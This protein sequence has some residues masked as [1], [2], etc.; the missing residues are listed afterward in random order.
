M[1]NVLKTVSIL[2]IGIT[3]AGC[4]AVSQDGKNSNLQFEKVEISG[5]PTQAVI[6]R[7]INGYGGQA[8]VDL[9]TITITSDLR[10]GW[11]GQGQYP[12]Y[13]DLDPMR[14]IYQ[15]D[16]KKSWGSEEAWGNSGG[17]AERIFY[18]GDGQYTVNYHSRTYGHDP[19]LSLIHI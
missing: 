16:L 4:S 11:L 18:A 19:E 9:E 17:Y 8:F 6:D 7:M 12:D 10:F 5:D 2:A 15:M 14:K 1:E 13:T 3:L